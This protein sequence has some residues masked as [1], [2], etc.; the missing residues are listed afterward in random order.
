MEMN[1]NVRFELELQGVSTHFQ[2]FTAQNVGFSP[3]VC[4]NIPHLDSGGEGE[5]NAG[6]AGG[7]LDD[8]VAGLE[9]PGLLRVL[10]HPQRDPVLTNEKTVSVS[11]N[12]KPLLTLT[13]PP[14]LKN[15]HLATEC[16]NIS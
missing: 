15:S 14:A 12:Q 11:A 10:H 1:K 7:G 2:L 8:R 9:H 13:E 5:A 6:V 3:E 16:G 4:A